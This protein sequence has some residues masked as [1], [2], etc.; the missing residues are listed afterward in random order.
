M[1]GIVAEIL[2]LRPS[3]RRRVALYDSITSTPPHVVYRSFL[4]M[5]AA[6]RPQ[7]APTEPTMTPAA[8]LPA[9]R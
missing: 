2:A 8:L 3:E 1:R 6:H 7:L 4:Q 5:K 9:G